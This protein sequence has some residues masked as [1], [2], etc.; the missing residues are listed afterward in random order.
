[1]PPQKV[2]KKKKLAKPAAH[3][4]LP[5]PG[6]TPTEPEIDADPAELA[7]SSG[8]LPQDDE[9]VMPDEPGHVSD[10]KVAKQAKVIIVLEGACLETGK[11]GKDH[12]L[13][14][15]DDHGHFLRKHNR[16][17]AESR[18]DILHQMM[19]MALDSPLNKAGL[20]R[21]YVR[22]GKGVLIEVSPQIR[23]PRTFKRFAGLMVQLLH[24]LSIRAA[25][26]PHKLLKVIKNPI[27]DHIPPNSRIVSM[28]VQGR[29]VSVPKFI[30]TLPADV[31]H[32]YVAGAFAHGKVEAEYAEECIALS[33]YP[34]SGAAALARLCNGYEN[35]LGIL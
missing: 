7:S 1:M 5:A 6:I 34:L 32:V 4:G 24:K 25:N 20:L 30:P 2:I 15:C 12:V 10:G 13:L 22:T 18:P 19:L 8:A 27:T 28:S 26:G 31:P 16:D 33:Q 35:L 9:P 3:G 23:I 14:N 29:L 11:V 21:L 17:P